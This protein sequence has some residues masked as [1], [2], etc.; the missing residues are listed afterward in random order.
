MAHIS[1]S[2]SSR[3]VALCCPPEDSRRQR[4]PERRSPAQRAG[5]AERSDRRARED[6]GWGW[7]GG[8][9]KPSQLPISA[10]TPHHIRGSLSASVSAS[11]SVSV[12]ASISV[13]ASVSASASISVSVSASASASGGVPAWV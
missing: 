7:A 8:V 10:T 12:S 5:K 6:Y 11:I 2:L 9:T 13:S 3:W 4:E 1:W